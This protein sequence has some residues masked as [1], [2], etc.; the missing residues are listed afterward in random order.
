MKR[1]N[2]MFLLMF[3]ASFSTLQPALAEEKPYTEGSI[4][5]VVMIRVKP[6][7]RD[8]YLRELA[9]KRIALVAAAKKEGLILSAHVLSGDAANKDDWNLM[10]IVEFKNWEA[11]DTVTAKIDALTAK[12]YGPEEQQVQ[13][14]VKRGDVRE[15]VGEKKMQELILK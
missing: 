3:V 8:V 5:S 11:F 2:I 6:G 14:F 4:W 12:I 7:M 9:P 10:L 13:T 1:R 15:I